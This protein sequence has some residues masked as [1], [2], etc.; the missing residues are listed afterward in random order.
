MQT[1]TGNST[2]GAPYNSGATLTAHL[3][4]PV[5]YTRFMML[6]LITAVVA[7]INAALIESRLGTARTMSWQ[8]LGGNVY[9]A[10]VT[11][12]PGTVLAPLDSTAFALAIDAAAAPAALGTYPTISIG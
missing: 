1:T 8:N 9:M 10:V 3:L 7:D 11:L 4:T 12:P 5:G 2:L 6:F